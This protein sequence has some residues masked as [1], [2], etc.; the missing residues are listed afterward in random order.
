MNKNK[1]SDAAK[2]GE[3]NAQNQNELPAIITVA[4]IEEPTK[5]LLAQRLEAIKELSRL[6]ERRKKLSALALQVEDYQADLNGEDE[7]ICLKSSASAARI[8]ISKPE[9]VAK[10]VSIL[11]ADLEGAQR[12]TDQA[13]LAIAV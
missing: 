1:K 10:F 11:K 12:E 4:A 9:T 8:D 13:I 3:A 6:V 7:F 5:E 2:P